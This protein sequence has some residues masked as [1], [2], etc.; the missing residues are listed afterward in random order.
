[1][2]ILRCQIFKSGA[3]MNT[4]NARIAVEYVEISANWTKKDPPLRKSIAAKENAS[5]FKNILFLFPF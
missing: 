3:A 2:N 4:N 5:S 1:L